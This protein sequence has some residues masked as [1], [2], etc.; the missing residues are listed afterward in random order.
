MN[1]TACIRESVEASG[2]ILIKI[3]K[4]QFQIN[5]DTLCEENDP[6]NKRLK[7]QNIVQLRRVE[8]KIN[9]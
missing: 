7:W 6:L 8:Q 2:R 4:F 1:L 5:S 3:C 9:K